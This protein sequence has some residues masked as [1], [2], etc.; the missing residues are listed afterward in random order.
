M[1]VQNHIE[2][3]DFG[4]DLWYT[5]IYI[6]TSSQEKGWWSVT[7]HKRRD[8]DLLPRTREGMVICYLAQEKG[9]W[10]VTS[11]KRR[12]GD[13]LP[14]TREGMVIRYL[15]QEKGWWSVTSHKPQIC[16]LRW[17]KRFCIW[18][19]TGTQAL[20]IHDSRGFYSIVLYDWSSISG[21]RWY[22]PGI[23]TLTPP[24]PSTLSSPMIM[25]QTS[26]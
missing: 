14:H 24:L 5:C 17:I 19:I 15:A 2:N 11:H 16:E 22:V 20:F 12:D 21:S 6:F 7:S 1:S 23:R 8:G 25:F 10:S 26:C 13:P 4:N 9:W 3:V 18:V